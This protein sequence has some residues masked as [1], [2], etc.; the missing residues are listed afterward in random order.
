MNEINIVI[1]ESGKMEDNI[2]E[3]SYS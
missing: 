2:N 3:E 1:D